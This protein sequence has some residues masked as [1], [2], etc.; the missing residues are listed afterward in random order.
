[1]PS[2]FS[3]LSGDIR[4]KIGEINKKPSHFCEGLNDLTKGLRMKEAQL[5]KS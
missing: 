4:L 3:L 1:M 2:C 5:K